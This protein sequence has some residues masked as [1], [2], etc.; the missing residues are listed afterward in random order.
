[1]QPPPAH[2]GQVLRDE[3]LAGLSMSRRA[4]AQQLGISDRRLGDLIAG[5]AGVSEELAQRLARVLGTSEQLW[6]NLQRAWDFWSAT[7]DR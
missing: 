1:M 7:F 4:F 6:L 3:Y 5:R 2:P